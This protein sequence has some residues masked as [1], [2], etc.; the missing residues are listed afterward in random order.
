MS[1]MQNVWPDGHIK[2]LRAR[3]GFEIDLAWE[4][5]QLKR[6]K[7]HKAGHTATGKTIVLRYGTREISFIDDVALVLELNGQLSQQ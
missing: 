3:G 5:G 7:L 2:G 1:P 4:K 6:V